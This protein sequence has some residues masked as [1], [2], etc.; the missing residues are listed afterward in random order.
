MPSA[1]QAKTHMRECIPNPGQWFGTV[2]KIVFGVA[3]APIWIPVRWL[4][5]ASARDKIAG[6][7]A[8]Q[9]KLIAVQKQQLADVKELLAKDSMLKDAIEAADM[10]G[11]A[12]TLDVP[13]NLS[14]GRV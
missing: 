8:A 13:A 9:K 11:V 10:K 3:T 4:C 1:E 14:V 6:Q 5:Q 12:L 2:V 7:I